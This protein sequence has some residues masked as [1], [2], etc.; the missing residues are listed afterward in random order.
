M[1]LLAWIIERSVLRFLVKQ[2]Q[3]I[4]FMATI[5]LAFVLEGLG[6]LLFGSDVKP[7]NIGIPQGAGLGAR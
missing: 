4:L 6:D 2:D 7:L 5:G 1:I 3:I